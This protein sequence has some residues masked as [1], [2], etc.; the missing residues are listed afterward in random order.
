M[1]LWKFVTG[2]LL[3]LCQIAQSGQNHCQEWGVRV[4][5]SCHKLMSWVQLLFCQFQCDLR[6]GMALTLH[7]Q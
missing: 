7:S 2:D 6:P 1:K 5:S 4:A 3:Q